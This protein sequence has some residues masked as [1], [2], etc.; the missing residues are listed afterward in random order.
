[1]RIAT[2]NVNSVGARLPRL[3]AWLESNQPDVLCLQE[4]KCDSDAFPH[5]EVRE[6]GY[7]TAAYGVGRWNGVAILSRVGLED[8]QRGLVDQPGYEDAV[9]PRAIGATCGGVR[10]WSV[11]VPNGRVPGHAHYDYKLNW[12][13]ALR[14]TIEAEKKLDLPFAVLGDFNIAPADV[15]VWDIT[16]YADSTH[17][18]A[19]EREALEQVLAAGLADVLP[20]P[21]KY[22][23]PFTYWDYRQLAFPKNRGMRIDLV[24]AEARFADAITDSYVDREERKGKGG[25]DHAPVVVDLAL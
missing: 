1:M 19:P 10:V 11:Y 3:L 23:H 24:L 5:A 18:T 6:L 2:W 8:V 17:V 14:E 12:L 16:A 4:L 9:E 21:L 15:D 20:R 7:E 13:N 25:S 22:D